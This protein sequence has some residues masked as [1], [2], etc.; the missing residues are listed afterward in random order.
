MKFY[1][2]CKDNNIG[3]E[4]ISRVLNISITEADELMKG[5]RTFTLSQVKELCIN[6]GIS[7]D[8]YFL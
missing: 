2:Y 6:Y 4:E 3:N 7:A 8:T 1:N 5:K